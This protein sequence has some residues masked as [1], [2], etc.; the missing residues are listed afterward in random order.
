LGALAGGLVGWGVPSV[1]ARKYEQHVKGGK[2]VVLAR[3]D[4]AAI[5]HAKSVL[6]SEAPEHLEI[7]DAQAGLI[8][9]A[10]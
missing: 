8:A 3:G 2:F 1:H 6:W 5:E 7:F 4:S 10:D 9:Q